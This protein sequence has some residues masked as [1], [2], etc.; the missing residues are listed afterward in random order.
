MEIADLIIIPLYTILI[1]MV[2]FIVSELFY[3][4]KSFKKY[5]VPGLFL[6]L[7]GSIVFCL[8]YKFYYK[9]GDT[10][11]YFD[12][13]KK[14]SDEI[15]QN[16]SLAWKIF[17]TPEFLDINTSLFIREMGYARADSTFWVVKMSGLFNIFTFDNF[18]G[19]ALFFAVFGYSGMWALF[20]VFVKC[21]PKLEWQAALACLA[22]PSM[23]FWGSGIMKD[24][25]T[26]GA[27]GWLVYGFY[28]LVIERKRPIVSLLLIYLNTILLLKIKFY[29]LACLL[30]AL[31]VWGIGHYS[32]FYLREKSLK[33]FVWF[34]S[35]CFLGIGF[36][37]FQNTIINLGMTFTKLFVYKAM[38]F[39]IW[40][41][42]VGS[43][44]LSGG[45]ST[46][47]LGE[48]DFTL[49]G[50]LSKVPA[51]LN[52]ALF[53]PYFTEVHSV[54]MVPAAFES[55]LFLVATLFALFFRGFRSFALMWKNPA[56]Q[57]FL[58]FTLL[59][60]FIVGFTS[61]NFG[62]LVRYKIPCMPF[63]S[64][65]LMALLFLN[66]KDEQLKV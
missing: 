60:A 41:G 12:Q 23:I 17:N 56:L 40:H 49:A 33:F 25:I 63:F 55:L 43:Q 52:V 59:F 45:G 34:S 3:P 15:W 58:L 10:F 11:G 6:K 1:L 7:M 14:I 57:G 37:F 21:F 9:G 16:P 8:I 53:R 2:G 65:I 29:I 39:Q 36:Y 28:C 18:F 4:N 38:D 42:Y 62:A 13:S 66:P 32:R 20:R 24:T 26:L 31:L 27:M 19:T 46:Y 47:S 51:S 64:F 5:F 30:P 61:F 48:I 50:V 44:G 54:V 35:L 22:I